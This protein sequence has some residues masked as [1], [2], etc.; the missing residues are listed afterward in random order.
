VDG[1]ETFQ[2][3]A[4]GDRMKLVVTDWPAQDRIRGFLAEIA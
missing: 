4:A 3:D 2:P 1:C